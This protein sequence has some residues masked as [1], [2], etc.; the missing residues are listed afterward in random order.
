MSQNLNINDIKR[1]NEQI[2]TSIDD[3]PS[4][5][6]WIYCVSNAKN[7]NNS[8]CT[9][10]IKFGLTNTEDPFSRLKVY[11]NDYIL[12]GLWLTKHSKYAEDCIKTR[13]NRVGSGFVVMY[14]T[15]W[16]KGNLVHFL[17]EIDV[18]V[19]SI[20]DKNILDDYMDIDLPGWNNLSV[21]KFAQ[22]LKC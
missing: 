22:S 9:K 21:K 16:V 13:I 2:F 3:I 7:T 10:Y 11:G 6:Q 14:G 12:H 5:P 15:E 18:I 20:N 1:I 8:N 4:L 17:H 19:R